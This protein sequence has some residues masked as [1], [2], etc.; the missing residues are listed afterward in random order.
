MVTPINKNMPTN[1]SNK[2]DVFS[3]IDVSKIGT[4]SHFVTGSFC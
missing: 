3:N 1:F 2:K 4:G